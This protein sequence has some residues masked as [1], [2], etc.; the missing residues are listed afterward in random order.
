VTGTGRVIVVTGAASG[1]GQAVVERVR[2]TGATVVAVD[3]KVQPSRKGVLPVQADVTDEAAA[4]RALRLAADDL[5]GVDGLVTSAGVSSS[6]TVDAFDRDAVAR[7]MEVN[8]L[9]TALWISAVVPHLRARGG[10]RIVTIA[11]QLGER[12]LTGL[13]YYSAS[14]AAVICLSKVAAA[15]L[16]S[17]QIAINCV[18]PGPTDT[19]LT[20]HLQD[21]TAKDSVARVPLGRMAKP[22]EIAEPVV[23]LLGS[24]ASFITGA[25]V[26]V[27]GGYCAA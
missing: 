16:A 17:D 2:D 13:G 12:P 6:R 7:E 11:S 19:P 3:L 18:C 25:T 21:G 15:E 22:E 20:A 5:G 4:H 9:G 26:C 23:F 24:G 14:K 8:F 10:G 27:D 1:I